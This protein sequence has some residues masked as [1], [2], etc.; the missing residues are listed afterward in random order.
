MPAD[1]L[2]H[3]QRRAAAMWSAVLDNFRVFMN[4]HPFREDRHGN[5]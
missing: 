3:A 4:T 5:R 2:S 1:P